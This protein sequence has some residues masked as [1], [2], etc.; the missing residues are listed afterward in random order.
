MSFL[1]KL[2]LY[3]AYFEMKTVLGNICP[4]SLVCPK[5]VPINQ[6]IS[7]DLPLFKLVEKQQLSE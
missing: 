3:V 4:I 2:R 1:E 6:K 7:R 5:S